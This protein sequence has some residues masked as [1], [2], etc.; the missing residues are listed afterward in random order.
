L[1]ELNFTHEKSLSDINQISVG[2][3]EIPSGF[4][5]EDGLNKVLF[6]KELKLDQGDK[7]TISF[8]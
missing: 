2:S 7:L 4:E 6:E 8:K 3:E 5:Q 1:K